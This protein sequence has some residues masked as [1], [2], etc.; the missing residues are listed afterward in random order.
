MTSPRPIPW[1]G[2]ARCAACFS[3]DVDADSF[4]H[5]FHPATAY[6]EYG[7]LSYLRFDEVAVPR[8]VEVLDRYGIK[9]TFF[10]VAWCIERYPEMCRPIVES[11]HEI[12]HHGYLHEAPNGQSRDGELHWLQRGCDVIESFAGK[13]PTGWRAP[14]AA[15]SEYS[16]DLL[17]EEGFEYDSSLMADSVPHL[18]A[19]EHGSVVELPIDITMSDWPHYAHVPDVGYLMPVKSPQ[20]GTE[21]FLAEFDAA[22]ETGGFWTTVW[23]PHVSGR[24]SRLRAMSQMIEYMLGKG[25]VWLAPLGEIARHVRTCIDDGSY[26]PRTVSLP[27]YLEPIPEAGEVLERAGVAT[28]GWPPKS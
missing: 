9:Q 4:L 7:A 6:R 1:P 2:G 20:A 27:Y 24:P 5:L 21:A 17:I 18:I 28:A 15:L 25:D 14:H 16:L 22:Y 10:V 8:I 11:G 12:A 3:F 26:V 23:H 13:R 19:N